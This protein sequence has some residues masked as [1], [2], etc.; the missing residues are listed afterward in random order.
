MLIVRKIDKK[1]EDEVRNLIE[2]IM[3]N[4]FMNDKKHY[5]T[6]DLDNI[7]NYY[8]GEKDSFFVAEMDG[9]IIGTSAVKKDD[10]TTAL[11]RRFFVHPYY[12]D[13]GYGGIL[14]ESAIDFCKKNGYKRLVFRGTS[15]MQK[16]IK[17]CKKK[18]FKEIDSVNLGEVNL[19][20][21]ALDLDKK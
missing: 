16:A 13:K 9:K 5:A 3:H 4:E 7:T 20:V 18:G 17:L 8:S 14:L 19:Y 12:R 10:D 2:S 15:R 6:A 21:F 11:L 1:D